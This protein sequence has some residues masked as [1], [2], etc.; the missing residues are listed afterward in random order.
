MAIRWTGC[1][2]WSAAQE[3]RAHGGFLYRVANG[4]GIGGELYT[5]FVLIAINY[6]E[7]LRER[8]Y[9]HSRD[10]QY[11]ARP[12]LGFSDADHRL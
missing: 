2:G 12:L 6:Q 7:G 9:R 5:T 8:P 4:A 11:D 10:V 3:V 1:S